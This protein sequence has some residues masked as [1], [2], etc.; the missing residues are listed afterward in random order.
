MRAVYLFLLI[1]F[2]ALIV[3]SQETLFFD[4]KGAIAYALEHTPAFRTFKTQR[5]MTT[6]ATKTAQLSLFPKLQLGASTNIGANFPDWSPTWRNGL[7]LSL[8]QPLLS[9]VSNSVHIDIAKTKDAI[10]DLNLT[11]QRDLL[12]MKVAKDFF[13]HANAVQQLQIKKQKLAALVK[14]FDVVNSR[15]L[16]GI[17]RERDVLRFRAQVQQAKIAEASARNLVEQAKLTLIAT[18]TGINSEDIKTAFEFEAPLPRVDTALIPSHEPTLK[19]HVLFKKIELE[20]NLALLNIDLA[21]RQLWPD[22]SASLGANFGNNLGLYRPFDISP[23]HSFLLGL[24]FR[25]ELFDFGKRRRD[26][27]IASKNRDIEEN[28]SHTQLAA[29]SLAIKTMMANLKLLKESLKL[30]QSLLALEEDNLTRIQVDYINGKAQYLDVIAALN[31]LSD[32]K[33]SLYLA[34]FDLEALL[35]THRYY[36]GTLYDWLF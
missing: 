26:I 14:Q 29:E 1:M 21:K 20:R 3:R 34:L 2:G 36:E 13:A 16:Q 25:F 32:V 6:I 31:S 19:K 24:N 8:E 7:S 18:I 30:N 11:A 35:V 12:C 15:Y 22:L 28:A 4:L 9:A 10:A 5:E 23:S 17:K 27:V 33:S